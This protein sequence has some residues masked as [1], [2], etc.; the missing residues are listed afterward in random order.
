MKACFPQNA[1]SDH[2][3]GF[4]NVFTCSILKCWSA[5]WLAPAVPTSKPSAT[6]PGPKSRKSRRMSLTSPSGSALAARILDW[7]RP[8]VHLGVRSGGAPRADEPEVKKER[9]RSDE[10]R[11]LGYAQP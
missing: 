3:A 7:L 2:V 5:L 11:G 1:R 10:S 8:G 6:I 9:P 4:G